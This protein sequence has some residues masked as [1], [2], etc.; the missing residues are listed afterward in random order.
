MAETGDSASRGEWVSSAIRLDRTRA[1]LC[2]LA[3][4][5]SCGGD[6]P[7]HAPPTWTTRTVEARE[8][9]PGE[10]PPLLVLLHGIGADEDDLLPLASVLDP[11]FTVTSLRAP[12]AYHVG[13]AWFHIDFRPG[14]QVVPDVDQARETLADLVRW[15]EAAPA[16]TGTDPARTFLLGFSQGAMMSLGVLETA[17]E[18][19]AGVVALSGRAPGDLFP[20]RAR[21]E[22]I[23]AVPLFVAHGTRDDLLPVDNG[24][25]TRDT[26]QGVSHD[27]TYREFPVGHGIGD[28]ELAVVGAWLRAHLDG[29]AQAGSGASSRK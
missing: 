11:R 27:F 24:R 14:G 17:P 28:D 8:T 6:G 1:A 7:M 19:L 3:A 13:A 10:R 21:L 12:H 25:R 26:Y 16:R 18:R 2:A 4:L 23:A 22:A 29:G 15:I 5:A 9:S 20:R